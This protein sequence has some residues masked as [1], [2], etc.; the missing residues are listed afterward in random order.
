MTTSDGP[1]GSVNSGGGAPPS[2]GATGGAVT[3][4]GGLVAGTSMFSV[5]VPSMTVVV[6][7]SVMTVLLPGPSIVVTVS[8]TVV[9]GVVVTVLSSSTSIVVVLPTVVLVVVVETAPGVDFSW[10]T[11]SGVMPGGAL[12]RDE[13]SR[14]S[15]SSPNPRTFS[16]SCSVKGRVRPAAGSRPSSSRNCSSSVRVSCATVLSITSGFAMQSAIASIK[17]RHVGT[18]P[19]STMAQPPSWLLRKPP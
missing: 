2:G 6:V 11:L 13:V 7:V 16:F 12:D 17:N 3:I 5:T 4:G 1:G 9:V 18:M 10:S 14:M 8:S 19:L 15:G